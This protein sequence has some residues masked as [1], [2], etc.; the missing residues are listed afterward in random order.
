MLSLK[1]AKWM[2]ST[3]KKSVI[4][5]AAYKLLHGT[6][7]DFFKVCS[8]TVTRSS[9]LNDDARRCKTLT[10]VDCLPHPST[11]K[12]RK[13]GCLKKM[14]SARR[15]QCGF[16]VRAHVAQLRRKHAEFNWWINR[17]VRS[18]SR[19]SIGGRSLKKEDGFSLSSIW[20][21]NGGSDV[22]GNWRREQ[23][24]MKIVCMSLNL[25]WALSL[26]TDFAV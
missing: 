2:F 6:F 9:S 3:I 25:C 5:K 1:S 23:W 16:D 13:Q 10:L 7:R 15:N 12:K 24:N 21:S 19:V 26:V 14:R 17:R 20:S 22:P 8:K 11:L 18:I 4:L